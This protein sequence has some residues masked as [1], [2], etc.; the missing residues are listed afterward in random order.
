VLKGE[1]MNKISVQTKKRKFET[2]KDLYGI[3]FED[4]NRVGDGGIYP[5]MLR[6]RSF[7]DSIVPEGCE[8]VENG[9]YFIT[10][11]GYK[12]AFNNGEGLDQ[13]SESVPPTKIPAWYVA[14]ENEDI[15]ISLDM[16]DTLNKNRRSSLV[17]NISEEN[18]ENSVYNIGYMGLNV[19]KG[20]SYNFFMFAKAIE[21]SQNVE[22]SLRSKCG[23]K[24]YAS[25]TVDVAEDSF[26]KYDCVLTADT[27]DVDAVFH[28]TS[29]QKGT[30][31]LGFSSL[32]PVETYNRRVNGLRK[33]I[34][35]LLK[36]MNSRFLR[37]P[38]GCIVEGITKETAMK[39][40]D[41]IGPVWERPS[42]WLL[43]FYRTTNGLGFHEYLQLCEDINLEPMYV[44][45]CGM[46]CQHRKPD[47]FDDELANEYLQDAINAIEYA[48][49]SA[50]TYWGS[51]R[52]KNGHPEPFNLKYIEIGNENVGCEYNKRYQQF[53]NSL[54]EKFPNII[55]IA[56]IHTEHFGLPTEIVDE[57]FYND[58]EFFASNQKK[59]DNY[60]RKGPKI[61]VGE[62]AV[63]YNRVNASL[64]SALGEAVFLT[65]LEH[66]Q[67][68]V[69]MSCYAPLFLNSNYKSWFPNLIVFNNHESY[70]IPSYYMLQMMG[71]S[72]GDYVI[73]SKV[74]TN[75]LTDK[76]FGRAGL[77]AEKA[78]VTFSNVTIDG[79]KQNTIVGNITG[80][81][82]IINEEYFSAAN[83]SW[84]VFGDENAA[85]YTL[86]ADV[87]FDKGSS[88]I[89]MSVWNER[90]ENIGSIFEAYWVPRRLK[91]FYWIIEN[92]ESYMQFVKRSAVQDTS[93]RVKLDLD[94]SI[95][96]NIKMVTK[97]NK[98]QC[99]LN[100]KLV[101][102]YTVIPYPAISS[103]ATIDDKT[104][105]VIIKIINMS[106]KNEAVKITL[107][108]KV[109]NIAKGL[110]LEA[111]DIYDC[112]SF[113][114]KT[115]VSP[116]EFNISNA[117]SDF[118]YEAPKYSFSILR[119]GTTNIHP[120]GKF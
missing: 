32:M 18:T 13:W 46:T 114:N 75:M 16:D 111:S 31:K 82:K 65:G 38:G 112:N 7:E 28:I 10:P 30:L 73:E 23:K 3:F 43:W 78:G 104:N 60:D 86:S 12:S 69:T 48:T 88:M 118:V 22:I 96:N 34:V 63:T 52:A 83:D 81:F 91:S 54:K 105:E 55:Y 17:I 68:I 71:Q 115:N 110:I 47:Y 11:T 29:K 70:G 5:E 26:H 21:G 9:K 14:K 59:Y 89:K 42:H 49:A 109:E 8:A 45:N 87:R 24:V 15:Q 103:V 106:D 85:D 27:T 113:E 117:D 4:I 6:N 90:M 53:Y 100:D 33:D 97:E 92:G 74:E 19:Q 41:T 58:T 35:E 50:D 37:F 25:A 36:N 98:I 93:E 66:N 51:I 56:N 20:E 44:I 76:K 62:Y 40:A 67:D 84:C 72:R 107:D 2:S 119:L 116:R 101:H 64:Y 80:E 99:Y 39:F 108:Q 120:A 95:T 61:F 94:Y 77:Y 102:T 79:K 1:K 57:H